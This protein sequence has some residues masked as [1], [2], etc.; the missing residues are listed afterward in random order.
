MKKN[1]SQHFQGR[2]KSY[3]ALA[4]TVIA[5]ANS[6]NAQAVYTNISPDSTVTTNGGYYDLDL[7]NDGTF[8]FKFQLTLN[9][10][11]SY[12][13]YA[14]NKVG[15]SALDSNQVAGSANGAYIYPLVFNTAD[16]VKPSLTW[17]M[18][19]NQSMGSSWGGPS[20]VYGNWLGATDKFI[21]LKLH[22]PNTDTNYYGWA[23]LDV[24]ALAHSFTI[25]DYAVMNI[26]NQPIV[27]GS[28][29]VGIKE[30]ILTGSTIYNNNR[31]VYIQ[32]KNPI[33]GT[34]VIVN[35]AGQQVYAGKVEGQQSEINLGDISAGIYFVSLRSQNIRLTKKIVIN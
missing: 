18:G 30:N 3:S 28:G 1:Y 13:S 9:P 5:A 10:G 14:Y 34:V 4:G 25:K 27:I 29:Y 17:Y 2:L 21:G 26:P 16:T 11:S 19:S 35:A 33:V 6:A 7:N 20:Y 15:V 22:V 31:L 8:D 12:Y 23:R 24:E 32:T